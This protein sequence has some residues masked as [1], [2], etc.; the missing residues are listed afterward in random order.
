MCVTFPG[1]LGAAFGPVD[2]GPDC[3][4]G[5]RAEGGVE[6]PPEQVCHN[7]QIVFSMVAR[8]PLESD[9]GHIVM[10]LTWLLESLSECEIAHMV[11]RAGTLVPIS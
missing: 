7:S 11:A 4:H 6:G 10:F 3:A 8:E 2:S 1:L 9:E 5:A